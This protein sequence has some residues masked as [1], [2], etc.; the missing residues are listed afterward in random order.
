VRENFSSRFSLLQLISRTDGQTTISY[1]GDFVSN[2]LMVNVDYQNVYLPFRPNQPF[3]QALAFNG[4]LRVTGPWQVTAASNVDPEGHLRYSFGVSTYLYRM[5][6]LI[7][8]NSADSFSI[9]K[10]LIQGVVK[11]DQGVPVEGAAL[12]IGRQ[13]AYTDSTGHFMARFSKRATFLMS[14]APE[15]FINNGMYEVVSAPTQAAADREETAGELQVVI[16]RV[17]RPAR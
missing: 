5:N 1:G 9:P 10:Y 4:S 13:V 14:V 16:R 11:D 8:N 3:E 15:E 2:R 17:L 12:H 7:T 6:G